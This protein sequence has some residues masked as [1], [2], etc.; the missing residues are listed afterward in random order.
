MAARVPAHPWSAAG[1][2]LHKV[3]QQTRTTPEVTL[4][5]FVLAV[6]SMGGFIF[7]HTL[8]IDDEFSLFPEG[9]SG[10]PWFGQG[11]FLIG[12]IQLV[13]PQQVTPFF[14]YLLLACSYVA[15]YIL[16]LS[17]HEL[18]HGWKT[19]IG[20][21]IFILFPTNWLSQE[22]VINVPG[23]AVG[24]FLSILA[25]WIT[26]NKIRE[27][28]KVDLSSFSLTSVICL[29]IAIGG[30]QSLITVYLA[31]GP[32]SLLL[33]LL[34]SGTLNKSECCQGRYLTRILAVW[35]G[36]AVAAVALHTII[37]KLYLS[38]GDV[39]VHQIDRYF[40]SPYFMLR[41]QP[42]DYVRG[43]IEQFFQT[44]FT[45]GIF[46]GHSLWAFAALLLGV[47]IIA[48]LGSPIAPSQSKSST[49]AYH[50]PT[51]EKLQ[52]TFV[53]TLLLL[54]IP[55]SLNIISMPYRIPMRALMALPYVAWLASCLW[56]QTRRSRLNG[57]FLKIGA[58]LSTILIFQF[59]VCS[60][61]YYAARSFNNRSDQL[62]AATIAATI[63]NSGES[64]VPPVK[65]FGSQ[66]ALKRES[67][68]RVAW[69]STAGS[70][71]FNWDNGNNER[72]IRWLKAMGLD[73]LAAIPANE[74]K[75]YSSDFKR[76]QIWPQPGS[77]AV[78]GEVVL[79]KFG[80]PSV[81]KTE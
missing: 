77:I 76:M 13:I 53:L 51:P 25:A 66:G 65:R 23:F 22:F 61:N 58:I 67:P 69:Y 3:L 6:I 12:L 9:N 49:S 2:I 73:T 20:Y 15:S 34:S 32:G 30:F 45:P 48:L 35:F 24:L 18:Q 54:A 5:L 57:Q 55:L 40:R 70:S 27:S 16:L 28:P 72:M 41:T 21:L 42:L 78:K 38:L 44:Y 80:E 71:F 79:V 56:L 59:L 11:R 62:V 29:A 81:L 14:P 37:Y 46:Y 74:M 33:R 63:N 50:P 19:L 43:N 8:G 36:Q 47:P 60:S 75:N 52:I 39:Q 68:Y 1:P 4:A 10:I 31:I 26:S 7:G 64:N 17:L